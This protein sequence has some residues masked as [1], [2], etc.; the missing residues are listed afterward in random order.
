MARARNIKPG[1]FRNADLVELPMEARL[2]FIGLWTLADRDGRLEDRPKQIK[3]EI[4]P[5]DNVDCNALL[6]LLAE[7]G[8]LARYVVDGKRCLQVVNFTKHQNP[9]R[10]EKASTLPD[11]DGN[12]VEPVP[13]SRKHGASTVQAQCKPDAETVAIGLNPESCSLNPDSRILIPET[14]THISSLGE[15]PGARSVSVS[16]KTAVVMVIKAEGVGSVNP[17][18]PDLQSLI[19]QGAD[20]GQFAEA[21]RA[22]VAKGKGFAYVLGIVKGQLADAQGM[23]NRATEQPLGMGKPKLPMETFRERDARLGREKWERLT[24]RQH[25]DSPRHEVFDDLTLP[26][27]DVTTLEISQ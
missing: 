19:D 14:P 24:G 23:V 26:A 1:F 9:H 3:M 22:A 15:D 6:D 25:P 27:T 16:K 10:D 13:E 21:A 17:S 7:T 20:A 5:A 2:L 18:H 4:F 12:C 8:M 11:C